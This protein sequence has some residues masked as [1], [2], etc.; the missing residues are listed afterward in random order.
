MLYLQYVGRGFG[1]IQQLFSE[2]NETPQFFH[3]LP[4]SSLSTLRPHHLWITNRPSQWN[5]RR[6]V[7]TV[8]MS[9]FDVIGSSGPA[10][11][12]LQASCWTAP[13][14]PRWQGWTHAHGPPLRVPSSQLCKT[15]LHGPSTQGDSTLSPLTSW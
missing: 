5:G 4:F 9:D 3:Q 7:E 14:R 2:F 6:S 13:K 11:L 15:H 8:C 10:I 1:E 12:T